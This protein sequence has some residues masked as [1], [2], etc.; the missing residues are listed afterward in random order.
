[1]ILKAEIT[2]MVWV[3]EEELAKEEARAYE[4]KVSS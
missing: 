2:I 3:I 4:D 1:M